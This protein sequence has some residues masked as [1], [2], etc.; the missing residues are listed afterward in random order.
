[1]VSFM[2]M[3]MIFIIFIL[4]GSLACVANCI[5][6]KSLVARKAQFDA[7]CQQHNPNLASREIRWT[8][9]EYGAYFTV[10]LDGVAKALASSP[11]AQTMMG[12]NQM[13]GGGIMPGMM[14]GFQP[15]FYDAT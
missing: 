2:P 1:M 11:Q 12:L 6:M 14:N 10:E 7:I 15:G 9:G 5:R 8:V 4:I 3:I 13:L